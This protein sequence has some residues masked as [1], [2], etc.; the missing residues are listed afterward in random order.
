MGEFTCDD[1]AEDKFLLLA[2]GCGDADHVDAPLAGEAPPA[3]GRAG[4]L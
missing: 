2:A 1:K 3:G 4:Y